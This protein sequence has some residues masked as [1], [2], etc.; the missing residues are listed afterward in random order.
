MSS[1]RKHHPR[2]KT[3]ARSLGAEAFVII[4]VRFATV[5]LMLMH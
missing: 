4:L 2:A 1:K 3:P 5:L